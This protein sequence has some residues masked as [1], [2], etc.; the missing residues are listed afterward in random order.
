MRFGIHYI[1][2]QRDLSCSSYVPYVERAKR[3]GFDALEL[4]DYLILSM[5]DREVEELAA[6]ARDQQI[7]LILGLDPPQD[8]ALT[9][10]DPAQRAAGVD[11]YCT[12]LPKLERLGI[13]TLGGHFL[14]AVPRPPQ[15]IH[16]AEEW[17]YGVKSMRTLGELAA[18]HGVC[19]CVE[20]V[21][22]FQGHILN[23]ARQGVRFVSEVGSPNVKL[24][25]DTF[26]MNIEESSPAGAILATGDCLGHFHFVDNHRGLPG[27]GHIDFA[28]IRDA[29]VHVGYEGTL[30]ME[31]L[32]RSG[33]ALGDAAYLWRDLTAGADEADLDRQAACSLA[34]MRVL[35]ANGMR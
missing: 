23:T 12:V 19:L 25:L 35:F 29:L 32:V 27:T 22:R 21:N 2:W 4:G 13:A 14:N 20:A 28:S 31:A 16:A 1:Y 11:F 15:T 17:A 34:G 7:Q 3:D 18:D 8:R 33:G 26:H 10:D 6:A 5:S 9:A 24:L 30:T